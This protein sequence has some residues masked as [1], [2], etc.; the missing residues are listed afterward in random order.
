MVKKQEPVHIQET[1]QDADD[2]WVKWHLCP[3]CEAEETGQTEAQVMEANF[4]KPMERKKI[5]VE[6]YKEAVKKNSQEWLAM[7]SRGEKRQFLRVKLEEMFQ[8]LMEF[9]R[10]KR[11]ALALVA[12][13]VEAHN[14]L[15]QKLKESSSLQEDAEIY[16]AMTRLEVGHGLVSAKLVSANVVSANL[17]SFILSTNRGLSTNRCCV[18]KSAEEH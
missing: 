10:L 3:S 8:P 16:K 11:E 1:K 15:V 17:V 5:R 7:G 6:R 13:D 4:K 18:L 14:A 12:K 2:R 9:L